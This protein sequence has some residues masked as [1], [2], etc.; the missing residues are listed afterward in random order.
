MCNFRL[1]A[2]RKAEVIAN[3]TAKLDY[4]SGFCC[5]AWIQLLRHKAWQKDFPLQTAGYSRI[6]S[7]IIKRII[8]TYEISLRFGKCLN[9]LFFSFSPFESFYNLLLYDWYVNDLS[10]LSL[11]WFTI[12][13]PSIRLRKSLTWKCFQHSSWRLTF[14]KPHVEWNQHEKL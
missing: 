13:S 5:E 4:W 11:S 12:L 14:N 10:H 7:W 8:L 1:G 3:T 6:R 2:G 9:G